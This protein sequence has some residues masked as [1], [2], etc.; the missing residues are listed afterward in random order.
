MILNGEIKEKEKT[1]WT[2]IKAG[3]RGEKK[4]QGNGRQKR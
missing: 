2:D 1:E 4:R 3:R